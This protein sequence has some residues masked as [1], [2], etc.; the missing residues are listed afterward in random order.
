VIPLC[1]CGLGGC[2]TRNSGA[3]TSQQAIKVLGSIV[4]APQFDRNYWRRERDANSSAW[5]EAKR[6]CEETVLTNYPNC[7]P[8]ND[9]V[10]A[11]QRKN[12]DAGNRAAEKIE[13]MFRRGY[14]FDDVRKAWL[15]FR[16]LQAAGCT[17]SY[18]RAGATTWQCPPGTAIPQGIP[19]PNFGR[20]EK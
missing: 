12:A 6:L 20:E 10:E 2:K 18:P 13:E 5:G 1:V 17:Y 14:Q 15:P 3:P 19:D 4:P 8:I 9:I 7:L 11:D 16:E